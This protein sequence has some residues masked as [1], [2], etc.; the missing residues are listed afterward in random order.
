MKHAF[1][2]FSLLSVWLA[3]SVQLGF[4]LLLLFFVLLLFFGKGIKCCQRIPTLLLLPFLLYSPL[5][6]LRLGLA[7]ILQL[8]FPWLWS[9]CN[10]SVPLQ[11]SFPRD[12]VLFFIF[13]MGNFLQSEFDHKLMKHENAWSEKKWKT[14]TFFLDVYTLRWGVFDCR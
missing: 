10:G 9:K 13:F 6:Q 12:G 2:L 8:L 7:T 1:A 14:Q 3:F 5:S 4:L 11:L